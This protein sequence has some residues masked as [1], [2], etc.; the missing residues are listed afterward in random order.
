[1]EAEPPVHRTPLE[2][3]HA[4]NV[5]FAVRVGRVPQRRARI[6]ADVSVGDRRLGQHAEA[7]VTVRP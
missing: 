5:R 2:A 6:A 3:H 1:W 7:L 4:C